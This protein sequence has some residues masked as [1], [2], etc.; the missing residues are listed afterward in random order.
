VGASS[1]IVPQYISECSP[2]VIRGRL[3]GLF[4]IFLQF[5]QIIGFWINYGTNQNISGLRNSQWRIPFGFQ[6]VP[7]TFLVILMLFQP[8]SPRWLLKSGRDKQAIKNLVRI[9]KLPAD[10]AYILWEVETVK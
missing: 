10:D 6:L 4:E 7:G 9:R 3:I 5:S 1:L 8:E 2:P